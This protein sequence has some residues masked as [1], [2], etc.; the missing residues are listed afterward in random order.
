MR[1]LGCRDH[2]AQATRNGPRAA[3]AADTEAPPRRRITKRKLVEDRARSYFEALGA[4]DTGAMVEHWDAEGVA[5]IVP[6]GILR[7]R[8]ELGA[9]FSQLFAAMPDLETTVE[10]VAA[11]A[12]L[13]AVEWRM[14]G[15]FTGAPF[16]DLEPTG[17]RVDLRGIDLIEIEDGDIVGNTAYYDGASF[18]RQVGMLPSEGSGAERAMKGA[19]NAFT[20]VRRRVA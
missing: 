14:S 18:A 15:H 17:R 7:G 8:S 6:Y 5:D 13:A 1:M 16:M 9:F 3:S 2:M 19:F 12:H 20:K 11:T 4:R 10:R